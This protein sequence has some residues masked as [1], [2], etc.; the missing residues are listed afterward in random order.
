MRGSNHLR[1]VL[2]WAGLVA[3][4]LSIG[5]ALVRQRP[6]G[7]PA[8][9]VYGQ[10]PE[11]TLTNQAGRPFGLADLRGQVWVADIIFTRCPGPC[12]RMSAQ[13]KEI[14]ESLPAGAPV[15]LVSLTSDPEFDTVP[16]LKSYAARFGADSKRWMF[17]TGPNP[18]VR[19]LAV[20]GLKL[21]LLDKPSADRTVPEDL[22]IHS[23]LFV[24][25]DRQGRIRQSVESLET[26]TRGQALSAIR[27]LLQEK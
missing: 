4:L 21:V 25:V 2:L 5:V 13:M 16:V 9:P 15:K 8:F 18:I 12:P 3:V 26:A 10:V 23:T 22:F 27:A 1:M 20:N 14:Q 7:G 19:D 6:G 11:F 24:V 17:L